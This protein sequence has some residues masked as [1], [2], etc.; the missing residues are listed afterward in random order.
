VPPERIVAARGPFGTEETRALLRRFGIGVLVTKDGGEAGGVREKLA[1]ARLEACAVVVV[2]RPTPAVAGACSTLEEL[3]R[4]VQASVAPE[5]GRSPWV[6]ALDLE[7]VLVPEVWPTVARMAG[8]PDLAVTTRDVA[9]YEAL[10]RRR[11]AL[12]RQHGLTLSRLR[13]IM[14]TLQP[15]P[16]ALEFLEWARA[17]ALIVIVSDTYHELAWPAAAKL[18]CPLMICNCLALDEAGYIADVAL[19]PGGKP[20]AILRFQQLGFHALAVGDSHNDIGML[21]AADVGILFR[22]CPGVE[23]FPAVS[24]FDALRAELARWLEPK[25]EE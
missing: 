2:R 7:S 23:G 18:D 5:P 21:R 1:A 10:M 17:R 15:L 22:P 13:A 8:V 12:C 6:L 3:L 4:R 16:G 25:E 14:D 24:S 20:E 19:R 11:I 9:D